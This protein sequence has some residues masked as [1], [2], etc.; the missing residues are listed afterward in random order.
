[1]SSI[2]NYG[3]FLVSLLVAL[4]LLNL[5]LKALGKAPIIG[6]VAKKAE[7]LID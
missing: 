5:A 6:G 2:K 1:M 7:E 3:M 4:I